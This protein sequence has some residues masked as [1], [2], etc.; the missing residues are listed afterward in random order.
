M[1]SAPPDAAGHEC[2]A[3][4]MLGC[5]TEVV[6][7]KVG[8]D[9]AWTLLDTK[10]EFS[11]GSIVHY[12]DKFSAIDCTGEISVYSSNAAGATSTAMLL[13]SL[14]PPAG[15][16]HRSYLESNGELHIVSVMVST[17]HET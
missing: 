3:M 11:V 4:A 14:S 15:I 5:S 7:C 9:S 1:L 6:F 12:Q 16:C 8:V 2:V 17:C 10:L 13:S